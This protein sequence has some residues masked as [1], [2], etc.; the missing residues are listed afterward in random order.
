MWVPPRHP[1]LMRLSMINH[2]FWGAPHL[3]K[4]SHEEVWGFPPALSSSELVDA[5]RRGRL[6]KSLCVPHKNRAV[7]KTPFWFMI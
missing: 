6:G 1:F 3:W 4:P 2:P 7:F 5:N